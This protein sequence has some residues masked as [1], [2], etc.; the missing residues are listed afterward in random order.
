ML[1]SWRP[2]TSTTE[3]HHTLVR[4]RAWRQNNDSLPTPD[5]GGPPITSHSLDC[6][7]P[8]RVRF[9]QCFTPA[10]DLDGPPQGSSCL[11]YRFPTAEYVGPFLTFG[12]FQLRLADPPLPT[13][14]R[15][16]NCWTKGGDSGV[17]LP[18]ETGRRSACR[19][20]VVAD[21]AKQLLLQ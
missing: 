8:I 15:R 7:Y 17:V 13:H 16:A 3:V 1:I 21:D 14:S 20:D 10:A 6:P 4:H 9:Q 5:Y 11:G 12:G 18:D 19:S 2:P